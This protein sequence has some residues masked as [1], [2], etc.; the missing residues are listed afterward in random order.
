MKNTIKA[1]ADFNFEEAEFVRM[2]AFFMKSRPK[3]YDSGQYGL[4]ASKRTF[5]LAVRRTRAKR[6]LRAWIAKCGLSPDLDF[7]FIA[8][9]K[10]LETKLPD[11]V[12]QMK[13]ALKKSGKDVEGRR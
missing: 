11:G 10:I 9:P 12:T 5:P 7:L 6:L 3:K 1:H 2:P 13:K 8:R 4:V